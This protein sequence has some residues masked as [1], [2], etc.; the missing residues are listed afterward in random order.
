MIYSCESCGEDFLTES[1]PHVIRPTRD[2]YKIYCYCHIKGF[3]EVKTK[4]DK[5]SDQLSEQIRKNDKLTTTLV[6]YEATIGFLK[7]VLR[8]IADE[9]YKDRTIG[10]IKAF[11][12]LKK[13]GA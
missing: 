1:D 9:S 5:L 11:N 13:I 2:G 12:A 10:G 7:D 4:A 6:S 8:E 3:D